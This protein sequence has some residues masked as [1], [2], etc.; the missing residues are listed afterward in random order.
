MCLQYILCCYC[1]ICNG[2]FLFVKS[3][4]AKPI[5][6]MS[7]AFWVRERWGELCSAESNNISTEA[8]V[9]VGREEIN[10]QITASLKMY[11]QV[12][13]AKVTLQLLTPQGELLK[14]HTD[15]AFKQ[16]MLQDDF[17]HPCGNPSPFQ[18]S[19]YKTL[20]LQPLSHPAVLIQKER[21][22]GEGR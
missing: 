5:C 17:N 9:F 12:I 16:K 15:K 10:F 21:E 4:K 3:I 13:M 1:H 2:K 7:L 18:N 11:V 6:L 20:A 8:A 14:I 19:E 22:W